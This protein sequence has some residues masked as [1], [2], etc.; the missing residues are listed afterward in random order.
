ME[1]HHA[2]IVGGSTAASLCALACAVG[3]D[4]HEDASGCAVQCVGRDRSDR[5]R[6]A[7]GSPLLISLKTP[8]PAA[9]RVFAQHACSRV[10]PK[11][12]LLWQIDLL[13]LFTGSSSA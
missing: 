8:R 7:V 4:D 2:R 9:A 13:W 5:V 1:N 6:H 3:A 11:L 10:S 12:A